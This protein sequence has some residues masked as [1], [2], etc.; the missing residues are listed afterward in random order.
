MA[1]HLR[2]RDCL[3]YMIMYNEKVFVYFLSENL[4]KINCVFKKYVFDSTVFR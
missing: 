3:S 1:I 4:Y 2:E